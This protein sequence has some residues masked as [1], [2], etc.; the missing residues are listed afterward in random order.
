V[1][2]PSNDSQSS[3]YETLLIDHDRGVTVVTLNRPD[4]MNAFDATMSAELAAAITALD[5]ADEVRA[6]VITGAGRA[7]SAG[8]DVGG[9]APPGTTESDESDE[10]EEPPEPPAL[11]P[12]ELRTP[13]I[14]AINGAAVGMGLT[15]PLMWDIRIA[16]EDAKLGLVF[17][18]RGLV[19]EGNASWLLSRLVG[20]SAALELLLTG[21]IFSGREAAE[22]GLVT[23]AVPRDEVLDQAIELAIDIAENTAPAAVAVTKRLFYKQLTESDRWGARVEE[24]EFFRWFGQQPDAG[25]GVR[26]FLEKRSPQW[27]GI[28]RS[29]LPEGLW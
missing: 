16:A 13:I 25:E 29:D 1:A 19:P 2:G 18:R 24:L 3:D 4:H 26:S 12:W 27:S 10:S 15:Y 14:A 20:A 7:F 11:R 9:G 23:R 21:R 6:I 17:T 8:A 28:S 22:I 5:D